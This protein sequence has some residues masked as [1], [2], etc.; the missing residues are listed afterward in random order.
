MRLRQSYC[1]W[2]FAGHGVP[3][4][5]LLQQAKAIG[6]EGVE[7]ISEALW[8]QAQDLG[9]KIVSHQGQ[10]DIHLGWNDPARHSALEAQVYD[11]LALAQKYGI[12][13][14][15][16]FSGSRREGLS[17]EAGL[18]NTALGLSRVAGAAEEAGV[19]LLLELLNSKRDHAGY[20]CDRT[21]WGAEVCRRVGSPRVKLL[22]DIYHMQIME[23][24]LIRTIE[25][26]HLEIG[27]YHTAGNPGR[28]DL[29]G[30]QEINYPPLLRA[31]AATGYTGFI[32]HE[33][34]PKGSPG[35]ALQS[36]YDLCRL[37]LSPP[38]GAADDPD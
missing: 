28:R 2:I 3:D 24:D 20:Q 29:D 21:A 15:I 17:E 37:S 18:E 9:L 1:G 30:A 23:G 16:V 38:Q 11:R 27:H 5:E 13:N 4:G 6:Y 26:N 19:T 36:A 32:G 33:F 31:I 34:A 14:L 22:Y 7:L 12:V 25:Q 10:Q 8:S 35:A